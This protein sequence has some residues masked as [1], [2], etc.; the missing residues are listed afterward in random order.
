MG[1]C[2]LQNDTSSQQDGSVVVWWLE[3]KVMRPIQLSVGLNGAMLDR[4]YE[5]F[6]WGIF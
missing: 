5:G 1:C 4:H 6:F 3:Q 2:T